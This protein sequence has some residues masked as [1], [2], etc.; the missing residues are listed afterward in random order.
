[1]NRNTTAAALLAL[2]T[3]SLAACSG[4]GS[5]GGGGGGTDTTP[6]GATVHLG[7]AAFTPGDVTINHGTAVRW[8]NDTGF[9]HTIT[10]DPG[11]AVTFTAKSVSGQNTTYDVAFATAG[12]Y[13]YHCQ[14]HAGMT[15]VVHVN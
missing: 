11:Q 12:T 4:G 3:L 10:P 2:A 9:S 1:M 8:V 7:A 5:G 13:A 6:V 14:I 15:G